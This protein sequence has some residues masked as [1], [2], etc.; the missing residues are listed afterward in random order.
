MRL[1]QLMTLGDASKLKSDFEGSEDSTPADWY[2][3]WSW[4]KMGVGLVGFFEGTNLS[5]Y[6]KTFLD[7]SI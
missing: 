2:I 1:G 5:M 4:G 7:Y 6:H 3:F